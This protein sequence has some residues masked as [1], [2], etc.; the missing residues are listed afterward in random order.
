MSE[1]CFGDDA[2]YVHPHEGVLGQ[3]IGRL[4]NSAAIASARRVLMSRLPF[5]VLES[6]VRDVVYMTWMVDAERA[7]RYVPAGLDLWTAAAAACGTRARMPLAARPRERGDLTPFTILTYRHGH[8]GP[9]LLGRARALCPSPLQSNWRFYLRSVP[10]GAPAVRTVLFVRNVMD[11]LVYALGTRM[12]SD[13]LPTHLAAEFAFDG[14]PDEGHLRVHGGVG[15]APGLTARWVRAAERSLPPA[16]EAAFGHW[17]A[18]LDY[19]TLQ[20]AAIAPIPHL[21]RLA[22][23]GISLPAD[24][25]SITPLQLDVASLACPFVESLAP[26][27]PPLCF[28]LPRVRFKALSEKVLPACAG[29]RGPELRGARCD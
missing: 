13:A 12:F 17:S 15:S 22:V 2:Y 23:A 6:D 7:A 29:A 16:F 19:L 24:V 28:H 5:P 8:F 18:A 27:G 11:S 10:A 26:S 3:A 25:G 21:Q 4:A 1:A 20:D 9:S 14:M